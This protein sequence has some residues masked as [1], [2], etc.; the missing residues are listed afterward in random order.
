MMMMM[1]MMM[2]GE[3]LY[4]PKAMIMM[5]TIMVVMMRSLTLLP[6][7]FPGS[8]CVGL[9]HGRFQRKKKSYANSPS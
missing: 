8:V 2:P 5:M 3:V 7:A 6:I 4:E 9:K 1:M